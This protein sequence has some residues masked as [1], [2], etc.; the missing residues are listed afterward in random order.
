MHTKKNGTKTMP[1]VI[2]TDIPK[3]TPVP[4]PCLLAEPGPDANTSGSSPKMKDREVIT[5]GR[6]L[7]RAAM[8]AAET[9]S[10][11]FFTSSFAN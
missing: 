1:T 8:S 4:I 6:N 11:P 5:I 2:A 3:N 7:R 10:F 9:A